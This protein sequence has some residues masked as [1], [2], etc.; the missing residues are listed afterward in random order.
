[1]RVGPTPITD[2]ALVVTRNMEDF[3]TWVDQSSKKRTIMRY[4]DQVRSCAEDTRQSP[5]NQSCHSWTISIC[6]KASATQ[7]LPVVQSLR[8]PIDDASGYSNF[9]V[10]YITVKAFSK[11]SAVGRAN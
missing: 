9:F 3:I 5:A 2:P 1:M 6:C 7:M 4:N 10:C 8:G 11:A